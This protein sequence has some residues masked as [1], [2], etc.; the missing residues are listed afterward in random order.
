MKG[1]RPLRIALITGEVSGDLYGAE[2][3]KRLRELDPDVELAGAGGPSMKAAGVEILEDLSYLSTVGFI[4]AF[5][6]LPQALRS[7]SRLKASILA[8]GPDCIVFIDFPGFNLKF[9][10]F[11]AQK[12]IPSVY[13]ICPTVWAWGRG[14][15]KTIARSVTRALCI[16]PFEEKIYREAGADAIFIGHPILD[17]MGLLPERAEARERLGLD[18]SSTV[19]ALLPGSRKQEIK[20]LLPVMVGA[21]A[22]VSQKKPDTRAILALAPNMEMS[23]IEEYISRSSVTIEVYHGRAY[24]CLRACD[25]ALIASG[26]ATLEAAILGAPMV[27]TYAISP[28]TWLIGRRLIKIPYIGLP[29]ILAGKEIVPELLQGEAT[30]DSLSEKTLQLLGRDE[31]R[32]K[33]IEDLR[34][35]AASLGKGGA[36]IRAAQ[37]ILEVARGGRSTPGTAERH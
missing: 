4:E 19:I 9:A 25:M 37:E 29:N 36:I 14:R 16:F 30:V 11:A 6:K 28:V 31:E 3:A 23:D 12:G 21:V 17:I 22:K 15:A 34:Q 1:G 8:F 24:E 26:T 33:M 27:I 5:L 32:A 7:F 35:V 13:F 20:R 10:T 2:L 18:D